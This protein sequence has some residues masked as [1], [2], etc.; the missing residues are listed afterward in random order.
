MR[1]RPQ[2][3]LIIGPNVFFMYWPVCPNG[4]ETEIL[5]QEK[6]LSAGLGIKTGSSS[7]KAFSEKVWHLVHPC[8]K[9]NGQFQDGRDATTTIFPVP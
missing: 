9:L 1:N 4:P 3:L 8:M 7:K 6:P 2:K 5:Y